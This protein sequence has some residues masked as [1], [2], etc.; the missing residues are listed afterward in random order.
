[1]AQRAFADHVLLPVTTA[2]YQNGQE[3]P[4]VRWSYEMGIGDESDKKLFDFIVRLR[5]G[6]GIGGRCS[7]YW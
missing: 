1:M 5:E 2:I 6:F 7:S 3:K 4:A